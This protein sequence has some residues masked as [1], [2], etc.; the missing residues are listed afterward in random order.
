MIY[1]SRWD[2]GTLVRLFI[3]SYGPPRKVSRFVGGLEYVICTFTHRLCSMF[4]LMGMTVNIISGGGVGNILVGV[5]AIYFNRMIHV[6]KLSSGLC[7]Q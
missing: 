3:A 7:V 6:N 4:P 5:K 1:D 2:P